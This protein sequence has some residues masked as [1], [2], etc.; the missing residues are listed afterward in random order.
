M[1]S[2]TLSYPHDELK[3][4]TGPPTADNI[5]VMV[6]QLIANTSAITTSLG[7]GQHGHS[8]LVYSATEYSTLNGPVPAVL[9]T[10]YVVPAPPAAPT[11]ATL[12]AV[13]AAGANMAPSIQM[14]LYQQEKAMIDTTIHVKMDM[15][16]KLIATIPPIYGT[17][18]CLLPVKAKSSAS[19]ASGPFLPI[20]SLHMV[21]SGR[22]KSP[23]K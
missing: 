23:R 20:W 6:D 7:G 9:P 17:L 16:C 12:A 19:A 11:M 8:G 10:P 5:H 22:L 3:A 18:T 2:D 14:M 4:L 13:V 1:V 15:L 21:Q